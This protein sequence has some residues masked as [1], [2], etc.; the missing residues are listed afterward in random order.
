MVAKCVQH[1]KG[2]TFFIAKVEI[3]NFLDF[4]LSLL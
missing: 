4:L 1:N 2:L 3:L